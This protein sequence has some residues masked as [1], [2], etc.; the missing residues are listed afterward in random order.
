[1][2]LA[3]R[4]VLQFQLNLVDGW[5]E[6]PNGEIIVVTDIYQRRMAAK[7][8]QRWTRAMREQ[9]QGNLNQKRE[10]IQ[11]RE[12]LFNGPSSRTE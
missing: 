3:D 1:M 2:D 10:M 9:F 6:G 8:V 5:M 12:V 4:K 11:V 7:D